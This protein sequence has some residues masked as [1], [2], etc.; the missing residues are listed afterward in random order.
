MDRM[1]NKDMLREM[2]QTKAYLESIC[3]RRLENASKFRFKSCPLIRSLV[4]TADL[5]MG[6]TISA[7]APAPPSPIP[8]HRQ[9]LAQL[10]HDHI[11]QQ[12]HHQLQLRQ[13]Q[14]NFQ[15]Q[16]QQ[17]Q[18]HLQLQQQHQQQQLQQQLDQ[19]ATGSV[20]GGTIPKV[21]GL[22]DTSINRFV[23]LSTL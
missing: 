4:N 19:A 2:S 21:A 7:P 5:F 15:L 20:G 17:Q 11:Q 23:L 10:Q 6:P 1:A 22:R 13:Q 14:Q 18:Q 8:A 12:Q 3:G 9:Q 16:Q